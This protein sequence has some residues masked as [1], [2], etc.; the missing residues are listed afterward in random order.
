[1]A[2]DDRTRTTDYR[3]RAALLVGLVA[4][5]VGLAAAGTALFPGGPADAGEPG[6]AFVVSETNVSVADADRDPTVVANVSSASRVEIERVDSGRFRVSTDTPLSDRERRRAKAIARSN[7]T[8]RRALAAMDGYELA[9][10]PIRKL[11]VGSAARVNATAWSVNGSDGVRTFRVENVTGGSDGSVVVGRSRDYVDG[12]AS[13]EIRRSPSGELA[14]RAR[15][16]LANGT[17][18]GVTDWA[19][20]RDG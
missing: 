20:V 12:A 14:Y 13:V 16:D 11:T 1:M 10:E 7:E 4:L 18:T 6:A 17:V 3:A 9:V 2:T 15:V 19:A 5:G 8:V